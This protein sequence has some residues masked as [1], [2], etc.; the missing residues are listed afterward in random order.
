MRAQVAAPSAIPSARRQSRSMTVLVA[1]GPPR[2]V[3]PPGFNARAA[4]PPSDAHAV[5]Y[6][7]LTLP[8][9]LLV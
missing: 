5:S 1:A 3:L 6:R 8:T 9:I 2:L 4:E 7:H